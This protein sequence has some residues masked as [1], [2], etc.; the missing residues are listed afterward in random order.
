VLHPISYPEW[1]ENGSAHRVA[2]TMLYANHPPFYRLLFDLARLTILKMLIGKNLERWPMK[3]CPGCYL[4]PMETSRSQ[5]WNSKNVLNS[6]S[7]CKFEREG[8]TATKNGGT[9]LFH[10]GHLGIAK[11]GDRC[12]LFKKKN[13]NGLN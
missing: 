3:S 5:K 4:V 8:P 1:S 7:S 9:M 13:Q 10:L 2:V 11:T 6:K 12:V